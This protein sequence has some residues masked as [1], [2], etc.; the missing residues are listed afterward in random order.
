MPSRSD[1]EQ[2]LTGGVCTDSTSTTVRSDALTEQCT[3]RFRRPITSLL[4]RGCGLQQPRIDAAKSSKLEL[5]VRRSLPA[6][7]R[8]SYAPLTVHAIY[9]PLTSVVL[10]RVA[11]PSFQQR[12]PRPAPEI[13]NVRT[14]LELDRRRY[15][16][17]TT[18]ERRKPMKN[19]TQLTLTSV[20]R[21]PAS[22]DNDTERGSK[23]RSRC[24][25]P[26]KV[27]LDFLFLGG[28]C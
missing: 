18:N 22:T 5:T 24:L 8:S 19:K 27:R 3:M 23:K 26:A 17:P 15:Q 7:A 4:P 6:P 12:A 1:G 16:H 13:S 28:R 9:H 11:P 21:Q 20:P 2:S 25:A 10:S 14:A